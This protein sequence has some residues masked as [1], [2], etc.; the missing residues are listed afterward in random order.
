[1]TTAS[2]NP[3]GTVKAL[4]ATLWIKSSKVILQNLRFDLFEKHYFLMIF[5]DLAI[6]VQKFGLRSE[7]LALKSTTK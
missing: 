1:M 5:S 7:V 3:F 4:V 6:N 2:D